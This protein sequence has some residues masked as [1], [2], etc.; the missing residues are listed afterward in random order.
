M[1]QA[2]IV[3]PLVIPPVTLP[4]RS[5]TTIVAHTAPLPDVKRENF[6]LLWLTGWRT[7]TAFPLIANSEATLAYCERYASYFHRRIGFNFQF[8]THWLTEI[9]LCRETCLVQNI[10]DRQSGHSELRQFEGFRHA[11]APHGFFAAA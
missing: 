4:T 2:D 10:R 9:I 3:H 1:E 11:V 7:L 6:R 5:V 8:V